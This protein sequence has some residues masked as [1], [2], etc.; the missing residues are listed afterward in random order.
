M[1]KV[2][3]RLRW[4]L[5][6]SVGSLRGAVNDGG[7]VRVAQSGLPVNRHSLDSRCRLRK[8]VVSCVQTEEN[9]ERWGPRGLLSKCPSP[10]SPTDKWGSLAGPGSHLTLAGAQSFSPSTASHDEPRGVGGPSFPCVFFPLQNP[11]LII[12]LIPF[13]HAPCLHKP[14]GPL[15][16]LP[17]TS[18][19]LCI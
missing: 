18:I 8:V 19:T 10:R 1:T 13:M 17:T 15:L 12:A 4:R 3:R 16:S 14:N 9:Q 6:Q 11:K 7:P 2:W 5:P